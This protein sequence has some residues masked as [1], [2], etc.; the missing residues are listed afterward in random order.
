MSSYELEVSDLSADRFG[1][2]IQ[3]NGE[4]TVTAIRGLQLRSP[5]CNYMLKP[6]GTIV[7]LLSA[8]VRCLVGRVI[9][10]SSILRATSEEIEV[11]A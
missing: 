7:N 8:V 5:K 4:K 2:S 1:Q 9:D 11:N 6:N 3:F 10:A